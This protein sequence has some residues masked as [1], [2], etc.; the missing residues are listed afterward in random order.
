MLD[1]E[2]IKSNFTIDCRYVVDENK[3]LWAPLIS[4]YIL[5]PDVGNTW[6]FVFF[7]NITNS[8]ITRFVIEFSFVLNIVYDSRE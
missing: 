7:L 8:G 1:I 3:S 2:K 5:Y 6:S 4:Q